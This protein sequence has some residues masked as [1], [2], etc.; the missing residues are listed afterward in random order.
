MFVS[1]CS[2]KKEAINSKLLSFLFQ[3]AVF[4]T[5]RAGCN[6]RRWHLVELASLRR[7]AES[8]D[9]HWFY[10]LTTTSEESGGS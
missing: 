9:F 8:E 4:G 3:V 6:V 10:E 1:V 2:F 7:G 5:F